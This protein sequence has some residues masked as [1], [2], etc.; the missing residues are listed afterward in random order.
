MSQSRAQIAII[1]TDYG[2]AID[3]YCGALGFTLVEAAPLG[4]EK[5][6]VVVRPPGSEDA[7]VLLA[8]ARGPKLRQRP[9]T[10]RSR[11]LQK[12]A[13]EC[14][15]GRPS[16]LYAVYRT[17]VIRFTTTSSPVSSR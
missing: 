14:V 15:P 12:G 17:L 6:T 5:R 8:K 11:I 2:E 3:A 7:A 1:V 4:T 10:V 16:P 9:N 13:A